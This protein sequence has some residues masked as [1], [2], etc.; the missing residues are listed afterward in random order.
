MGCPPVRIV[1]SDS[2]RKCLP[3]A[4]LFRPAPLEETFV[5]L[6]FDLRS[7]GLIT[8]HPLT[9]GYFN[10]GRDGDVVHRPFR[11]MLQ[12]LKEKRTNSLVA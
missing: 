5:L 8:S 9:T 3:V 6:T 10:Q 2:F 11:G 12:K 1:I 7:G 4:C